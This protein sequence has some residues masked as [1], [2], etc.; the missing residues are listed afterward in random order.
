[1]IPSIGII[2]GTII[3]N[4]LLHVADF[5]LWVI[6]IPKC[7]YTSYVVVTFSLFSLVT[8]SVFSYN[9][10]QR[11]IFVLRKLYT[12]ITIELNVKSTPG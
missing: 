5:Y 6:G 4:V 11:L 7:M 3:S 10:K 9:A 1:M 12:D 8:F 2:P